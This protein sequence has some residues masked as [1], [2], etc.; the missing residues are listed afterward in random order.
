MEF[1]Y[2]NIPQ[3]KTFTTELFEKVLKDESPSNCDQFLLHLTLIGL[4]ITN[5]K[6]NSISYDFRLELLDLVNSLLEKERKPKNLVFY[7]GSWMCHGRALDCLVNTLRKLYI[8]ITDGIN[9]LNK[10]EYE[11]IELDSKI[12]EMFIKK[13]FEDS[14]F[15]QHKEFKFAKELYNCY[16]LICNFIQ[17][18]KMRSE[19][20]PLLD[21]TKEK[22]EEDYKRELIHQN[23]PLPAITRQ[24]YYAVHLFENINRTIWVQSETNTLQKVPFTIDPKVL[25]LSDKSKED[26][27]DEVN[28]NRRAT[29]LCELT[30]SCTDFLIEI[31]YNHKRLTGNRVL[32]FLNAITYNVLE[33]GLFIFTLIINIVAFLL[34]KQE[35]IKND[36][37]NTYKVV[38]P[39]SFVH[40][41]LNVIFLICWGF[42]K[43]GLYYTIEENRYY[44]NH[45]LDPSKIKLNFSTKAQ[46]AI[47]YVFLSKREALTFI[48]NIVFSTIGLF[49]MFIYS[50]ELL[51]IVNIFPSFHY[52]TK[53]LRRMIKDV[54][55]IILFMIVC[56][57]V[58]SGL[59]YYFFG[60]EYQSVYE[61]NIENA[62]G[63][64][65]QCFFAHLNFGLRTDGGIGE[66]FVK[67]TYA[68]ERGYFI[69]LFFFNL[70]FYLI[71]IMFSLLFLGTTVIDFFSTLRADTS[72]IRNDRNNI[73]FIC[74]VDRQSLKRSGQDFEE[75][76]ENVH[77]MWSYVYYML[78]VMSHKEGELSEL[79]AYVKSQI[80]KIGIAWFPVYKQEDEDEANE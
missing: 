69:G 63:S 36:F 72:S 18:L 80:D 64:F 53:A 22:I 41:L 39:L 16:K 20:Q 47:L 70:I 52:M 62:C 50:F 74:G 4:T 30:K 3:I 17:Q 13:Y 46:I 43:F 14:E 79:E 65:L 32:T 7:L 76:V 19:L 42:G 12:T 35:G 48:W 8:K 10:E 26:F 11:Y 58:F 27:N 60:N 23:S 68:K 67:S 1:K 49:S 15:S 34:A 66:M 71:I 77:N 2:E 75:H 55:I 51:I 56:I 9:K 45:N 44:I 38:R 40:I 21:V 24:N 37:K 31:N 61:N 73:C 78:A 6:D 25:W 5:Y 54:L 28:R 57:Y 33:K 59:A 29:K